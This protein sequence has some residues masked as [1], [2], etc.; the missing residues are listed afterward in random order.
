ML[1]VMMVLLVLLTLAMMY[2]DAN[3]LLLIVLI[4]MNAPLIL[5]I[6][7]LVANIKLSN[8]TLDRHAIFP[9]VILNKVVKILP[10]FVMT[11]IFV[12]LIPVMMSMDA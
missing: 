7:N 4:T 2:K 9:A 3:T 12:L 1:T 10:L 8:A 6:A 5:A 11:T